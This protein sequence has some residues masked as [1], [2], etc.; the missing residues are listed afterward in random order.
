MTKIHMIS[1]VIALSVCWLSGCALDASDQSAEQ[2][3]DG[4]PSEQASALA[5]D[6]ELANSRADHQGSGDHCVML[7]SN[8]VTCYATF[9]E[10]IDVAS[11][12]R[13]KDAP[14]SAKRALEDRRF[15][16]RVD[17]LAETP[18]TSVVVAVLY[19]DAGYGGSTF[20][21]TKASGCDGN[22][23]TMDH[24]FANMGLYGWDDTMGALHSYSNCRAKVW[25]NINFTGVSTGKAVDYS[26][27]GLLDD[28]AS[29]IEWF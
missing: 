6:G 21:V 11:S 17:A 16:A 7:A 2:A 26:S 27:L 18:N 14:I 22:I 3:D 13:I 1:S 12:G 4:A 8:E 10:A 23:N 5:K 20:T 19:K 15:N 9:T 25:E 29:S 24:N 28:A